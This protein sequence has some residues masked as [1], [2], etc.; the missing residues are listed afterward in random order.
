M[1]RTIPGMLQGFGRKTVRIP[2]NGTMRRAQAGALGIIQAM[3]K[4]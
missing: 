4:Q 3:K 1:M 2:K